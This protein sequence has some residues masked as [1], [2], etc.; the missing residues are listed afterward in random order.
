MEETN[1]LLADIKGILERQN[2]L[3]E[4]ANRHL[5]Q[6]AWAAGGEGVQHGLLGEILETLERI[7][8]QTQDGTT[9]Q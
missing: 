3:L 1:I 9:I 8:Q 5:E 4:E 6:L 2:T 7:R